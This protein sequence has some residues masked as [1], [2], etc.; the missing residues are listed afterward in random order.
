MYNQ[1]NLGFKS[2]SEAQVL[3]MTFMNS[4][5]CTLLLEPR[6]FAKIS[7]KNKQALPVSIVIIRQH[8][9]LGMEVQLLN[10]N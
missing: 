9:E 7:S 1:N 5:H 8:C 10:Q 4:V 6:I 3:K 2:V